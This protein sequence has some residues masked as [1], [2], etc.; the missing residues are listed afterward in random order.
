VLAR[1]ESEATASRRDEIDVAELLST[2]ASECTAL[3]EDV[4]TIETDIRCTKRI[5]GDGK[6]LYSAV[7]NL[8]VN[9]INHTPAGGRVVLSWSLHDGA[10]VLEVEDNGEGIARAHLP[11]LT[12]RFYRADA[13]RSRERGGTGLGLAIVKHILNR[14]DARLEIQSRLGEGSR[15]RCIFPAAKLRD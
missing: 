10:G 5:L 1:L 11:R 7:T 12:E 6:Q 4:P 8:V 15:F 3:R 2:V 14:H 9:A 13:G